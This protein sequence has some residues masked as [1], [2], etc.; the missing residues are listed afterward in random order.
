MTITIPELAARTGQ[1]E[2]TLRKYCRSGALT[3]RQELG[4]W[5][6]RLEDWEAFIG[7]R[8]DSLPALRKRLE[9]LCIEFEAEGQHETAA[10][11]RAVMEGR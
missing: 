11:V 3:A 5:V 1:E 9:A 4:R 6:V 7:R 8:R 10:R 2:G